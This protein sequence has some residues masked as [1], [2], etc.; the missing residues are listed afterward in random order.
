MNIPDYLITGLSFIKQPGKRKLIR[1]AYRLRSKK[2]LEIG[3]PSSFF[4]LKG[5]FPVYIF[6]ARI[7]GVNFSNETVWEGKISAGDT[8]S[9][10]NNKGGHQYISEASDLAFLESA[11]YDFLLSCHSLE[12][13]AN[14]IKALKEWNRVIKTGG[15]LVLVLPDK[16][17]TFDNKR[18]YTTFEHL[19][20]DYENNVGEDDTTHFEEVIRLHD[21]NMDQGVQSGEALAQRIMNNFN[22]RCV[23]HHIFSLNVIK[24]VLGYAGFS[25]LY[26]QKARPFHLITIAQKKLRS[27]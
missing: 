26:Q 19:L 9:Y 14:P 17:S 23:H 11:C 22:N 24:Q 2:G 13:M 16:E 25:V 18:P 3:G 20:Q 21:I 5:Y 15:Y 7:D 12:H 1:M 10:Y 4:N 6:A 8:Y 27:S